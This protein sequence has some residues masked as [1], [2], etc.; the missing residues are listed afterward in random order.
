MEQV[1]LSYK[2][3]ILIALFSGGDYHDGVPGC[4]IAVA[5]GLARAGFAEQLITK[6]ESLALSVQHVEGKRTKVSLGGKEKRDLDEFLQVWRAEVAEELRTN[7]KKLLGKR[8]PKAASNLL[9]MGSSFPNVD[10]LMAYVNPVTSEERAVAKAV[11]AHSA[12]SGIPLSSVIRQT[13]MEIARKLQGSIIWPRDPSVGAIA[14][15]CED[16]FEWGYKEWMIQRFSNW[17]WEGIVCRTLRR[18]T[19]I[20]DHG[21]HAILLVPPVSLIDCSR[22]EGSS[23]NT[24][25]TSAAHHLQHLALSGSQCT[26]FVPESMSKLKS[27]RP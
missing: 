11:K 16:Y 14:K 18:K 3:L 9:N 25:T 1:S 6:V 12:A 8:S 21:A 13:K 2:D 23:Q 20:K 22:R 27:N 5:V 7:S 26:R 10:V 24:P 4:G 15:V 19:I 17:L